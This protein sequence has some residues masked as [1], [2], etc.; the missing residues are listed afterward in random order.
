MTSSRYSVHR[1]AVAGLFG[2]SLAW[3]A[4]YASPTLAQSPAV[5]RTHQLTT[6]V[7]VKDVDRATRHLVVTNANGETYR[8]AVPEGFRSFDTL[9]PGDAIKATYSLSVEYVISKPGQPLPADTDITL[10]ARAAKGEVPKGVLANHIVVTGA[11]LAIDMGNH[12]LKMV[13]PR[14][15]EVINVSVDDPTGRKAMA[16]LKV[17]DKITAYVTESLLLAVKPA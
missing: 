7:T 4:S 1:I 9:K 5:S 12:T 17:G 15:G 14:G 6:A 3:A 11:V 8:L 13:S 10:A 2:L 16:Q